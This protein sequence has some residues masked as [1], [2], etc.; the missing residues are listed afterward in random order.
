MWDYLIKGVRTIDPKNHIDDDWD[1]AIENGKVAEV[2]PDLSVGNARQISE[3]NAMIAQPGIIDSHLHLGINPYGFKMEALAGVTTC[4]DMAGETD[5][6]LE[7]SRKDGSGINFAILQALLPG[8]ISPPTIPVPMK[9]IPL[10][11]K[12]S[13]AAPMA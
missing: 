13:Q 6:I 4:L 12:Y 9:S 7:N 3:F 1:I 2:A 11:I 10:S 8:K 5:F